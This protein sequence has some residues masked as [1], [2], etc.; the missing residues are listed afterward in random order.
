MHRTQ[1]IK[2]N[3]RILAGMAL[4]FGL[5]SCSGTHANDNVALPCNIPVFRFA[6]ERWQPDPYELICL[7]K[8]SPTQAD[9]KF[10][11]ALSEFAKQHSKQCRVSAYAMDSKIKNSKIAKLA[12]DISSEAQFP[13]LL[14]RNKMG[15]GRIATSWQ[16]CASDFAMDEFF[17]S[18]VR[19]DLANRLIKG[20]SVVWLVVASSN[21]QTT[22][23]LT[24]QLSESLGML[25]DKI[26]LPEGVGL[27]GS[28]LYSTIPLSMKFSV[29]TIKRDDPQ[30]KVLVNFIQ[31]FQPDAFAEDVPLV[32]PVFGKARALE[33]IP[34]DRLDA[35]LIEDLTIFLSGACSCQV[36]DL[37]PGF[38]LPLTLNWN[39]EIFGED[40]EDL[41][42]ENGVGERRGQRP[43]LVPIAPGNSPTK[44]G[45]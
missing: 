10:I 36:K 28:E 19:T 26:P 32:V 15:R 22:S 17:K 23:K 34:G 37:N 7:T 33:V 35:N 30:E 6:L 44:S 18:P 45:K 16:G 3:Q 29:V 11:A 42:P 43:E 27:P 12:N 31:Q 21:D 4:A 9:R 14:V 40:I 2:K 41:P 25:Q 24:R 1:P 39:E 5:M 20:H 38:D 13:Y 8:S